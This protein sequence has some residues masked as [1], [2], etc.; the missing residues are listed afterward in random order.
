MSRLYFDYAASTPLDPRVK[1]AM[2]QA[3]MTAGN[4]SSLHASGRML[5]EKID[6]ARQSVAELLDVDETEVIF[7]SGATESNVAALD[8]IV[9]A[10]RASRPE[11]RLRI[12][13]GAIEHSSVSATLAQLR[14]Y[15]IAIDNVPVDADGRV[16]PED[17]AKAITP[18]TIIVCVMWANNVLGSIQPIAEIGGVVAAAR[19]KRGPKDPPLLFVCDAVQAMSTQPVLPRQHGIDALSLSAHKMYGPKGVGAL[20]LK[21]G[22]PFAPLITGGG[23]ES[24]RRSGTENVAGI[25]GLGRAADLLLVERET[26]RERTAALRAGL[27]RELR[28]ISGLEVFGDDGRQL[29]GTVFV[30]GRENGDVMAMKFDVAGMAVSA[31]SACDAGSRKNSSALAALPDRKFFEKGGIRISFGRFTTEQEIRTLAAQTKKL[32]RQ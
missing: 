11:K 25:V 23:Q 30:S 10:A 32:V 21:R 15:G 2:D 4:P 20:Y 22:T 24:G 17:I 6:R 18:D 19:A 7:T 26:D 12:A 28:A 29:P 8:G 9:R 14:E 13:A 1:E 5:R 27:V 3:A 16:S 31:G